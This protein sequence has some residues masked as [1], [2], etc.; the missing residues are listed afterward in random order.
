MICC[1]SRDPGGAGGAANDWWTKKKAELDDQRAEPILRTIKML[2]LE[3]DWYEYTGDQEQA[4]AR[5]AQLAEVQ[6][7]YAKTGRIPAE[8][9]KE[10]IRRHRITTETSHRWSERERTLSRARKGNIGDHVRDQIKD[11]LGGKEAEVH[12]GEIKPATLESLRHCLAPFEAWFGNKPLTHVS[13]ATLDGYRR[14]LLDL[15]AK[16]KI[17]RKTAADRMNALK[18]F[19]R[20]RWRLRRVDLPRNMDKVGITVGHKEPKPYGLSEVKTILAATSAQPRLR[21][22]TLLCLNCG[23]TQIDIANLKQS[24]IHD[25][26]IIRKRTK[27]EN[28]AGTPTIE[29]KLW[30]ETWEL[31]RTYRSKDKVRALLSQRGTP[32]YQE[33]I[34]GGKVIKVDAIR[35][36]WRRFRKKNFEGQDGITLKKLRK[37]GA[38]LLAKHK[39]FA[40]CR[41]LYLGHAPSSIAD[42]HYTPP[43]Q[44]TFDEAID[45]L[46]QQLGVK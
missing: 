32:L 5:A 27:E 26:R 30:G 2:E 19:L 22:W 17:T 41:F 21:L 20:N 6:R 42:Q 25:D 37:T 16:K 7:A 46:G 23:M 29:Y 35:L 15:I 18:Q 13:E 38:S 36:A 11:F 8:I 33:T 24:E 3:R 44:A 31:L 9:E 39:H 14:H 10:V 4:T 43:P 34:K 45:W 12:A 1:R 28:E 40:A